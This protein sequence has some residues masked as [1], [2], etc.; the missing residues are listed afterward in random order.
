MWVINRVHCGTA[1][2]RAYASPTICAGFTNF[3]Q[4]VLFITNLANRCSTIDMDSANL[5]RP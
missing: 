2:S 3:A 4:V 5:A 1:H